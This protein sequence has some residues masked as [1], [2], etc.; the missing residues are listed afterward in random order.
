[1][2]INV[3]IYIYVIFIYIYIFTLQ[4]QT[5]LSVIG[6]WQFCNSCF[7][8]ISFSLILGKMFA[9]AEL[10]Y[11]P[12]SGTNSR[13]A[14]PTKGVKDILPPPQ[15]GISPRGHS[16]DVWGARTLSSYPARVAS[17]LEPGNRLHDPTGRSFSGPMSFVWCTCFS[18]RTV[19]LIYLGLYDGVDLSQ[20]MYIYIYLIYIYKSEKNFPGCHCMSLWHV[21]DAPWHTLPISGSNAFCETEFCTHSS[22]PK[23]IWDVPKR[24]YK[25]SSA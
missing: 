2:Q 14:I 3:Y 21:F 7:K 9:K 10:L 16:A 23:V 13:F 5:R 25:W 17:S 20:H 1:M 6:G 22:G 15:N 11:S 24:I 18:E 19:L 4:N 8:F 12:K